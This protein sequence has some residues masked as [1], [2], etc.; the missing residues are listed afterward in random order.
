MQVLLW[1]FFFWGGGGR[2]ELNCLYSLLLFSTCGISTCVLVNT[3]FLR[4]APTAPFMLEVHALQIIHSI[5][6]E[7]GRV[8]WVGM[9]GRGRGGGGVAGDGRERERERE[10][11]GGENSQ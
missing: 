4:N 5:E 1:F 7:R 8:R 3:L 9:E 10:L 6:R 2:G 11:R